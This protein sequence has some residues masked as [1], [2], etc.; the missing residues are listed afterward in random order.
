ML[1]GER[2]VSEEYMLDQAVPTQCPTAFSHAP[3]TKETPHVIQ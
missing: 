2:N 1:I 3:T